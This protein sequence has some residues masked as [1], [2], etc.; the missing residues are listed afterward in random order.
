MRVARATRLAQEAAE[1][2]RLAEEK[3]RGG[4]DRIALFRLSY[5]RAEALAPLLRSRLPPRSD[6][7][8][9]ARTNTLIVTTRP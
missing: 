3:A 9:D 7:S 6:V 1:R 2:R 8:W 4:P 5:A